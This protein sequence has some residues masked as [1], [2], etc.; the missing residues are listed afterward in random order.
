M[1]KISEKTDIG[2]RKEGIIF[3]EKEDMFGDVSTMKQIRTMITDPSV[4][5]ARIMPDCHYGNGCCIGF[6]SKLTH[7]SVR[8]DIG[9]GILSYPLTHCCA[10]RLSKNLE[11]YHDLITGSIPVGNGKRTRPATTDL[12]FVTERAT[13]TAKNTLIQHQHRDPRL[14]MIR[15]ALM[16]F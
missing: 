14:P 6:T 7:C 2:E 15:R 5:N 12:S 13:A 11:K 9:C 16:T 10:K 1:Y 4:D 3:L 8:G